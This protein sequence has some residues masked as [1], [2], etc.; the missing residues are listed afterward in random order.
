MVPW[1][2]ATGL[3]LVIGGRLGHPAAGAAGLPGRLL[4]PPSGRARMGHCRPGG[5]SPGQR[6][7]IATHW[8]A[9]K[10][11][12]GRPRPEGGAYRPGP[13]RR[14]HRPRPGPRC[15]LAAGPRGGMGPG[16]PGA[17]TSP[18]PASRLPGGATGRPGCAAPRPSSNNSTPK[19]AGFR[20]GSFRFAAAF[21]CCLE[22]AHCPP[23]LSASNSRRAS[24]SGISGRQP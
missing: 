18:R 11:G 21:R 2:V 23:P 17:L 8:A 13:P 14:R 15:R 9:R 24:S 6:V 5:D 12:P 10:I 22:L 3:T 20:L 1:Q 19:A 7:R 4:G 16:R